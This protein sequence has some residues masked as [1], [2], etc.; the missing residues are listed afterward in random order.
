MSRRLSKGISGLDD[1][2]VQT[3]STNVS[4]NGT[5]GMELEEEDGS[6]DPKTSAMGQNSRRA[7]LKDLKKVVENADVILHVLDARDPAGT[8]SKTIEDMVLNDH[9]K[10]LV[11][12]L[13]K[14][15][16]VPRQVLAGWLLYLRQSHPCIPFK[17]N[18]QSQKHNLGRASGKISK[19]HENALNT[20]QAVGTEELI[21]L[22]K[23]YCR[24]VDG[25]KSSITVGIVGFPNVGKSSLVNS[26]T[27]QRAVQVSSTPGYTRTLQEVI[28]DKNV[29]LIDSP[30]I[31]FA[32]GDSIATA[33][34]N[35]VSV[36][37]LDDV[38]T[39]VQAIL[40]KCPKQYLMQLYAIPRFEDDDATNFLALVARATGKLKKGGI[41]NVDAA[42]RAVLQDWNTGKIKYFTPAPTVTKKVNRALESE[43][44]IVSQFS[45]QLDIDN[46]EDADV[47]VLDALNE[48]D[49]IEF[50]PVEIREQVNDETTNDKPTKNKKK[51]AKAVEAS[52]ENEDG[53]DDEQPS[54][55]R[56]AQK[57][58]KKKV[59]KV[60]RR[61]DRSIVNS[62]EDYNFEA[63][64]Q[65]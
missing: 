12:V 48:A 17:C 11:Y 28:L 51:A 33:L 26:L 21:G 41:V 32:D 45:N 31:V 16:L 13:N 15:D 46:L 49:D 52:N 30:G 6:F 2:N 35:C 56:K 4:E 9:R 44:K 40:A 23:N 29:K 55:I 3:E 39:P 8:R 37:D 19:L 57:K 54:N 14:A 27:R 59:D 10:R 62:N 7:F 25:V 18:V 43:T 42:A 20:Q 60:N 53:V 63:D 36:D 50:V 22:L 65:Y 1:M 34:R 24:S 61:Q 58:D 38:I 47:R 5:S 64:F